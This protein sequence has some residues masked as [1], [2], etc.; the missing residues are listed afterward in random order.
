MDGSAREITAAREVGLEL[1]RVER[2]RDVLGG[3][4]WR[5]VTLAE[6]AEAA[7]VSRMTLHRRGIGKDEVLRQ[8]GELMIQEHRDAIYP[9]LVAAG[10]GR[11]RLRM[12]LEGLCAVSERYLGMIEDLGSVQLEAVFHE[13][14]EGAVL[15]REPFT[16][17]MRRILVDGTADG[18]LRVG[19]LDDTAT[20]LFNAV[21]WTYR[22]M[23]TGHRWAPERAREAVVDLLLHG[24]VRSVRDEAARGDG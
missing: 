5:S 2:V 19:D 16:A 11:E 20:L 13:P 18:T 23:R 24:T 10:D 22:H 8:L 14:G 7:G 1:D 4:E 12:A 6:L 17:G 21:G 9:A 3:R 15:T